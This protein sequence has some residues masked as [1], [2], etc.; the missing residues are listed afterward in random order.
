MEAKQFAEAALLTFSQKSIPFQFLFN[1]SI[2]ASERINSMDSHLMSFLRW[3]ALCL[4]TFFLDFPQLGFV[5]W[6]KNKNKLFCHSVWCLKR[7]F[8]S[9]S[10]RHHNV[11][12]CRGC[13]KYY[14]RSHASL[15][16]YSLRHWQKL[17]FGHKQSFAQRKNSAEQKN[18]SISRITHK[19]FIQIFYYA[20]HI[21]PCR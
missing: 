21:L 11:S 16:T 1:L 5:V 19:H 18:K 14:E 3:V 8:F 6:G 17:S 20:I 9:F 4:F 7:D 12:R 10:V 2:P 13:L 15:I